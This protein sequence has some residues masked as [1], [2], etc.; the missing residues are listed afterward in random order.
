MV[1]GFTKKYLFQSGDREGTEGVNKRSPGS[2]TDFLICAVAF[3]RIFEIFTI[4]KDFIRF[5]KLLPVTLHKII[6]PTQSDGFT[7]KF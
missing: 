3:N 5:Q 1:S 7:D 2:N 6:D 4:N